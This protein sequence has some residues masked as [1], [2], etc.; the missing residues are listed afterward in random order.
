MQNE[1]LFNKISEEI[2]RDFQ[3][4][5]QKI[6]KLEEVE[7]MKERARAYEGRDMVISSEEL[8]KKIKERKEDAKYFTG[9]GQLDDI[10]G[11]FRTKQLNTLTAATG[12]GKTTFAMELTIR[13]REYNPIWFPFEESGEELITKFLEREEKPPLFYLPENMTDKTTKWIEH[14]IIESIAK[15]NSKF[16]FIDHLHFIVPFTAERHDLAVGK[17]MRELRAI[18][19]KWDVCVFLICHLKK[20]RMTETPDLDDIRDSSL[21][22]QESDSVILLWRKTKKEKGE[23]KITNLT[24]VS[25]QKNRRTGKTGNIE[26]CFQDGRFLES[27]WERDNDDY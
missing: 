3:N 24:K 21:I 11:G 20:T 14:K 13:L 9:F 16:V 7:A 4:Q 12:S 18:A 23:I 10:V 6:K 27:A 17:T 26:M 8:I 25:V 22:S 2:D 19:K 15:Y 1:E 5:E